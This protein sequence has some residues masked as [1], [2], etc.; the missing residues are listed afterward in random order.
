MAKIFAHPTYQIGLCVWARPLNIQHTSEWKTTYKEHLKKKHFFGLGRSE[1][2][3]T[4]K[5][6]T[7]H[8]TFSILRRLHL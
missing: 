7:Q 4:R 8:L 3:Y 1:N 5:Y 2:E 6:L